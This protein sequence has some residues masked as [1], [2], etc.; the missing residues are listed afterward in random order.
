[1]F[2]AEEEEAGFSNACVLV[3]RDGEPAVTYR[4]VFP[5]SAYDHPLLEGSV[6]PGT[7]FPVFDCDFG[8]LGMQIC[9]D[10][11][12][13]EGWAALGATGAEVVVWP[14]MSPQ[15]VRP[16]AY[17]HEHGYH[18][19][20]STWRNNAT[21][22]SAQRHGGG[23]DPRPGSSACAPDRPELRCRHLATGPATASC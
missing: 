21:I 23:A 12:Y 13:P 18:V 19:V 17:A 9:F 6:T 5:V 2:L 22:F 11:C 15:T 14:T 16:A 4:K 20:T 8:R 10:G 3:G 7:E 1:M